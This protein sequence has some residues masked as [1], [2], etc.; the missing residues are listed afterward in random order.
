MSPQQ[1]LQRLLADVFTYESDEIVT[2]LPLTATLLSALC[3]RAT[4]IPQQQ[5]LPDTDYLLDAHQIAKRLGKSAKWVRDNA[6]SL[7]YA[8]HVGSEHRFSVR[9]LDE[10]INE[11]RAA[12][13]ASAL[14]PGEEAE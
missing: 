4:S 12:K 13:M 2:M 8:I 3:A 11:Q 7:V 10:W 1:T 14:P 5:S 6:E 9:G